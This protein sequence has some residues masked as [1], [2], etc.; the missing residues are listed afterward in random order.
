MLKKY[1]VIVI[2]KE[3]FAHILISSSQYFGLLFWLYRCKL[4]LKCVFVTLEILLHR[5]LEFLGIH[6]LLKENLIN[7]W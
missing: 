1:V 6:N 4:I 5:A 7:L 2:L 3:L